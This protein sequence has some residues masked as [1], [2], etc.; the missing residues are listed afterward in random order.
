MKIC[1]FLVGDENVGSA[2]IAGINIDR[3]FKSIGIDSEIIS[4]PSIFYT[5]IC[6]EVSNEGLVSLLGLEKVTFI[7]QKVCGPRALFFARL[8]REQGHRIVYAC[9]DWFETE[10]Y[11]IAHVVIVG[12]PFMKSLVENKYHH[13]NVHYIDD[14]LEVSGNKIHTCKEVLTLGWFGNFMKLPYVTSFISPFLDQRT[15]FISVSNTKSATY[16]MGQGTDRVWDVKELERIFL[17]EVDVFV[18]PIKKSTENEVK[19]GNRVVLAMSLG[20]PPITSIIS[21]YSLIIENEKNGF[22]V[23]DRD[24]WTN[25]IAVLRSEKERER[26]GSNALGVREVYSIEVIGGKYLYAFVSSDIGSG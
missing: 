10:M 7:F 16:C 5:D 11:N 2:R 17:E 15:K 12:S 6:S 26:I 21:T 13:T 20:I 3:Y 22:L 24:S 8:A 23:D 4:K 18:N 14:A 25:A 9:G 19:S 1:W